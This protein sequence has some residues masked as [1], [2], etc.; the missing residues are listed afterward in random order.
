MSLAFLDPFSGVSGDMFLGALVD[1]GLPLSTLQEVLDTL[2]VGGLRVTSDGVL[3]SGIG[4]IK[5]EVECP[6]QHEHR[7]LSHLVSLIE[8]SDLPDEVKGRAVAVFLR[9]ADAEAA[10]HRID[11]HR[12]H[13]HEVGAADAIADVVGTVFG[14]HHLGIDEL[15]VGSVNLGSGMVQCAHGLLPVPAPATLSLLHGWTCRSAG[16]AR[17]LTTPT[18]AALVTT[19]GRQVTSFPT[20]TV[21][22]V[23]YGAGGADPHGWP[24]LLRLTIGERIEGD[25]TPREAF[26]E[27]HG[28]GSLRRGASLQGR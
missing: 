22:R 14:L 26:Q 24:N 25:S 10:I 17:E 23:G 18:G 12:V 11:P 28:V 6:P 15:L 7:H 20:M 9:L 27:D 3:R 21:G 1:A 19:L 16:P 13:F 4:A 8:A 2:G 5:V